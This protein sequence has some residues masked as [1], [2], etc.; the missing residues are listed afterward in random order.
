MRRIEKTRNGILDIDMFMRTLGNKLS[1]SLVSKNYFWGMPLE[2]DAAENIAEKLIYGLHLA[3]C[4][5]ITTKD[6][7][8]S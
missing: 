1:L 2:A 8:S 3:P 7:D 6:A 4:C 5:V